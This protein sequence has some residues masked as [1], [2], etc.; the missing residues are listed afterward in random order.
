MDLKT[1]HGSSMAEALAKVKKD[2]GR[3]AV[4][5]HTRTVRRGGW[6]GF[7]GKTLVE[8]TASRD[9]NVLP[10]SERRALVGPNGVR[11]PSRTVAP[12]TASQRTESSAPAMN[13]PPETGT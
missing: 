4:I 2:L 8:I 9:I 11:A 7:G 1:Y 3:D 10:A 5:L 6:F 13:S 12:S